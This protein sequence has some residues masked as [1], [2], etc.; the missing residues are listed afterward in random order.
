MAGAVEDGLQFLID[1]GESCAEA[2][3]AQLALVPEV[4]FQVPLV[5]PFQVFVALTPV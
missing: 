4:V 2:L 5:A 1:P 3:F